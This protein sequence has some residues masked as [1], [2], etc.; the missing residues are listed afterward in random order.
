MPDVPVRS[1]EVLTF[2]EWICGGKF[3]FKKETVT[4]SNVG[5]PFPEA[6]RTAFH[7]R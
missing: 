1:L 5:E 7:W 6:R 3:W 4:S 2:R